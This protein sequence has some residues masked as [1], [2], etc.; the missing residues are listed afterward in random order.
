M[1]RRLSH[2]ALRV[3][4]SFFVYFRIFVLFCFVFVLCSFGGRGGGQRLAVSR[5]GRG[6]QSMW[7][8]EDVKGDA[9]VGEPAVVLQRADLADD[10]ADDRPYHDAHRK[11]QLQDAPSALV[12]QGQNKNKNKNKKK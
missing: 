12:P 2:T 9:R 10:H 11:A 5:E 7:A 6:S 1:I 3:V 4:F 8:K